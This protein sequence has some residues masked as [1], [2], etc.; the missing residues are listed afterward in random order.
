MAEGRIM[1]IDY[2]RKRVGLAVTD[3]LQLIATRL[4]TVSA[5]EIWKFLD[6]YFGKEKVT[7]VLIGYPTRMN[8][9][10]SE[11]VTYINPF[12]RNFIVR[13]PA[14]RIEQAD[15]RFTSRLAVQAMIEGGV[16]KKDRQDK[17]LVDGLSATILLQSYLEQKKFK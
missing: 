16:K 12:I 11:A 17:S 1:A 7:L 6:D 13:Y 15:E 5:H 8:N 9:Q 2:G 10:P 3:P 14:I 4:A